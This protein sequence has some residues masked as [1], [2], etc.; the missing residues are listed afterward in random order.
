M[1]KDDIDRVCNNIIF[2]YILNWEFEYLGMLGLKFPEFLK[3]LFC[4][5]KQENEH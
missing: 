1:K 2:L 3:L 4:K 5:N